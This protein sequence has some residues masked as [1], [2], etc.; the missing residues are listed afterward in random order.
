M[1]EILWKTTIIK[2]FARQHNIVLPDEFVTFEIDDTDIINNIYEKNKETSIP[3]H[4]FVSNFKIN[5][6]EFLY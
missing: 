2:D 1:T 3:L 5:K 6:R 4:Q